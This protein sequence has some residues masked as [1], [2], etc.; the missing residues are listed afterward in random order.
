M[1]QTEDSTVM[2]VGQWLSCEAHCRG[3]R[4]CE[5][6]LSVKAQFDMVTKKETKEGRKKE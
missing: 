4:D 5:D 3:S 2:I 1:K 6:W